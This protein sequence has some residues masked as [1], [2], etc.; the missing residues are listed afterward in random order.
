MW[1]WAAALWLSIVDAVD[2]IFLFPNSQ[3]RRNDVICEAINA[4]RS[5]GFCYRGG[6]RTVEPFCLG[7]V[8]RGSRR[9][10]SLLCYQTGGYADLVEGEGWKLYR[11]REIQDI[12]V[13][14]EEF[15][16]DRP[17]YDPDEIPMY[18]VYCRAVPKRKWSGAP[19]RSIEVLLR[20]GED[21]TGRGKVR[22]DHNDLMHRFRNR[23][24]EAV[25]DLDDVGGLG[26]TDPG[27]AGT[28]PRNAAPFPEGPS[29]EP[30]AGG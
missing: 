28:A 13:G 22:L 18:R 15:I 4:R 19:A 14:R 27:N 3:D 7:L 23:H 2:D 25:P 26:E 11:A 9:N 6:Q 24:P 10:E 1:Q 29:K 30:P 20:G 8:Q 16:G 5:I 17:G 21:G 12:A